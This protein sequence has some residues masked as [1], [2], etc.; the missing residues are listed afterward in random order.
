[1][2]LAP[3]EFWWPGDFPWKT[4]RGLVY[5]TKAFP[6]EP[7]RL[8]EWGR[9][10]DLLEAF[11][12]TDADAPRFSERLTEILDDLRPDYLI[13]RRTPVLDRL[14]SETTGVETVFISEDFRVLRRSQ[15]RAAQGPSRP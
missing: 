10:R 14:L 12:E 4:G 9:R 8:V 1:M 15:G 13:S 2:F 5:Q 7:M 6:I 11:Y 3:P